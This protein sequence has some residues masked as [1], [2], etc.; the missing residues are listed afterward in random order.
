MKKLSIPA[1]LLSPYR[2]PGMKVFLL[3]MFI[4]GIATGLYT[5][6]LN[7][8]LHEILAIT[9]LERGIV[10]LPRE[11]PGLLLF[12]LIAVLHRFSEIKLMKVA[13][14]LSLAGL[15]GL[16]LFGSGRALAILLVVLWSWGEHI[17]MPIRQ[18]V[19]IHAAHKGR[20]GLAMGGTSS[21]GNGGQVL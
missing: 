19:S 14:L 10:E 11:L 16:G 13:F 15:L 9:R 20:E 6:V 7:N 1:R 5:G 3:C 18:S 8:Y 17:M 4:F 21:V 2:D 12:A